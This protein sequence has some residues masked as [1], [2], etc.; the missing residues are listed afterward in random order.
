MAD[1][2]IPG[3]GGMAGG[4]GAVMW[5]LVPEMPQLASYSHTLQFSSE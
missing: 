5:T 4:G 3:E 1:A 2:D